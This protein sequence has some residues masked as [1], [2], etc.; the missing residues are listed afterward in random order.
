MFIA[1]FIAALFLIARTWKQPRCPST[2]EIKK[3]SYIYMCVCVCVCVCHIYIYIYI[4]HIYIYIYI[5]IYILHTQWDI[6]QP[7][8]GTDVNQFN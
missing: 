8:K 1:V 4:C 5:C 7:P 2:D 3:L 6:T